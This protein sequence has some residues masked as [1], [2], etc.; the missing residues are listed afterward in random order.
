MTVLFADDEVLLA[1]N[2]DLQYTVTNWKKIFKKNNKFVNISDEISAVN[3]RNH[4]ETK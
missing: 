2:K 4:T 3:T 1:E